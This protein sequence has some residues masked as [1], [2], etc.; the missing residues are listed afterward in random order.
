MKQLKNTL[1]IDEVQKHRKIDCEKYSQCLDIAVEYQWKGFSCRNCEE[2]KPKKP[3][4]R[5]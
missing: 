4:Y 3:K 1:K 5:Y 2:F